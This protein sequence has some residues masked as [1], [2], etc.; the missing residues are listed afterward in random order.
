MKYINPIYI[1]LVKS[2]RRDLADKW[3]KEFQN[4]Y[5]PIAV[6]GLRKIIYGTSTPR[7]EMMLASMIAG[8]KSGHITL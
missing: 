2:G 1:A 4:F 5:H 6:A 3:F 8:V 7:E